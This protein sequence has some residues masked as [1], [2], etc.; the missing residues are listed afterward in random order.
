MASA[1]MRE[2]DAASD[3][4]G[5]KVDGIWLAEVP[6]AEV[7]ENLRY[8]ERSAAVIIASPT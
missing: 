7:R 6:T 8:L 2:I 4:L 1:T 3:A 5:W